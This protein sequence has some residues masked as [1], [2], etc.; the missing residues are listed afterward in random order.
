M[1]R[2]TKEEKTLIENSFKEGL[3]VKAILEMLGISQS[4]VSYHKSKIKN[5]KKVKKIC[6]KCKCETTN[7][8]ASFCWNCGANIKS[9]KEQ[10]IDQVKSLMSLS[11]TMPQSAR[12]EMQ[13]VVFDVVEFLE[14]E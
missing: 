5:S 9:R 6:P 7:A 13:K 2:L 1:K 4:V 3:K 12:D 11:A 14:E 8:M 10:I